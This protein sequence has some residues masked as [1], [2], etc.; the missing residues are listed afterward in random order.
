MGRDQQVLEPPP[1]DRQLRRLQ[2]VG[3]ERPV[4][5]VELGE[6]RLLR[7]SPIAPHLAQHV[8]QTGQVA[9]HRLVFAHVGGR[10]QRRPPDEQGARQQQGGF[11]ASEES[12]D[13]T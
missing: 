10:D 12:D 7:L 2:A 6:Q 1:A 13:E 8:E 9:D 5:G 11:T 3:A 4:D